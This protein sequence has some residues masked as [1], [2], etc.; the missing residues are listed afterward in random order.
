[1][2]LSGFYKNTIIQVEA[3]FSFSG[4]QCDPDDITNA[5][6]IKPDHIM[7]QGV[8]SHGADQAS[9]FSSWSIV[10]ASLSKDINDHLRELLNRLEGC[11]DRIDAEF[12]GPGFSVIWKG[13]HLHA[14]SGPFY[15]P[16]VLQGIAELKGMLW[17]DIYQ[18]DEA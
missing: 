2:S 8:L 10:S 3:C 11:G 6:R 16:D 1:M 5:L 9:A 14:G 15:E 18:I 7:R 4:F 13:N 12:G 17:H